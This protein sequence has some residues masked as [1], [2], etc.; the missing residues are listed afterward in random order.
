[1]KKRKVTYLLLL[2]IAASLMAE[3]ITQPDGVSTPINIEYKVPDHVWKGTAET[4]G[5]PSAPRAIRRSE[6]K[7]PK[8]LKKVKIDGSALVSFVVEIDGSTSNVVATKATNK[9]FAIA[10]EE[11][12]KKWKFKPAEWNGEAVAIHTKIPV[13]FKP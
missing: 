13:K 8:E 6:A 5:H 1:M 10:A 3:S 7:Y 2:T 4:T 9:Y 12:V 11:A